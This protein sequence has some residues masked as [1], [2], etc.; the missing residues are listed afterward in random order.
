MRSALTMT[1]QHFQLRYPAYKSILLWFPCWSVS[2]FGRSE[3]FL[4]PFYPWL[5]WIVHLCWFIVHIYPWV[6]LSCQLY[7]RAFI[8]SMINLKYEFISILEIYSGHH[9]FIYWDEVYRDCRTRDWLPYHQVSE[10]V[11]KTNW[12][13]S[14]LGLYVGIMSQPRPGKRPTFMTQINQ[15][16]IS[17]PVIH[18]G[19]TWIYHLDLFFIFIFHVYME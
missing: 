9:P 10:N 12:E 14:A 4:S 17:L 7:W 11:L 13:L 5:I 3:S 8:L 2:Y 19:F 16:V 18:I 1:Q 6:N 15:L